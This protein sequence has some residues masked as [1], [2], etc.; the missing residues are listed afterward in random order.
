MDS[1]VLY[2]PSTKKMVSFAFNSPDQYILLI[3]YESSIQSFD[4]Y[5]KD[6]QNIINSLNFLS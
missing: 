6:I 1:S 3:R 2:D 4:T 5:L